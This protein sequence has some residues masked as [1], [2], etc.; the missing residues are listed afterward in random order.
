[1]GL[2]RCS[3]AGAAARVLVWK[4]SAAFHP[5]NWKVLKQPALSGGK[6]EMEHLPHLFFLWN[7]Y[8]PKPQWVKQSPSTYFSPVGLQ[9]LC[10][11]DSINTACSC[12]VN[13]QIVFSIKPDYTKLESEVYST[14]LWY[15]GLCWNHSLAHSF[16]EFLKKWNI[17]YFSPL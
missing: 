14:L 6:K 16:F 17:Y 7:R 13:I 4:R 12:H 10:H 15:A 3:E 8:N 1:M 9:F 11:R 2:P 5:K